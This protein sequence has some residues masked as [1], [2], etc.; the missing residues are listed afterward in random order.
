MDA[1]KNVSELCQKIEK[2]VYVKSQKMLEK[3]NYP[4]KDVNFVAVMDVIQETMVRSITQVIR[5]ILM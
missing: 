3:L 5:I 2:H 4:L 1:V